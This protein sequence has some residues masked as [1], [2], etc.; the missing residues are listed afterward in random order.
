MSGQSNIAIV[1]PV[2]GDALEL[3]ALVDR[4]H[5]WS[6]QPREIVVVSAVGDPDLNAFCSANECRY[7]E[8]IPCRGAQL[9]AGAKSAEAPVL[10]FLHADAVPYPSSLGD[11]AL[12]LAE[13]AESG[14][15]RFKFAGPPSWRK[16]LIEWLVKLRVRMRGIPYG[17]QG[18]FARRRA[19]QQCGGFPHQPLFEEV[20]L[21][22]KLRARKTF[23]H[24]EAPIGVSPRRWERD[25]WIRRSLANRR[26]AIRYMLG[27]TAEQL[28]SSYDQKEGSGGPRTGEETDQ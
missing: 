12:A 26:L 18:L 19:Y 22:K 3:R 8:S 21:V 15:F 27:A 9:D 4:I 2:L 11:I 25:G 7:L 24:L 1:V 13:G 16:E 28:A 14:H 17:D 6:E 23:R 10:W 20:E 5:S